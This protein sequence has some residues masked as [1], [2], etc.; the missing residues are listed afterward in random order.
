M[1][2]LWTKGGLTE[3]DARLECCNLILELS[4]RDECFDWVDYVNAFMKLFKIR[5]SRTR[6]RNDSNVGSHS[7]QKRRDRKTIPSTGY[8]RCE[9]D[10]V[11][12]L[13]HL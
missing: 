4:P 12:R 13:P 10:W 2:N 8:P 3:F 11:A 5:N 6:M 9:T 7:N 1:L